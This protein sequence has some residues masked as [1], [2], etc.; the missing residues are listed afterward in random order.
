MFW[1]FLF[2]I[3]FSHPTTTEPLLPLNP[4]FPPLSCLLYPCDHLNF[5]SVF[6]FVFNFLLLLCGSHSMHPIPTH[7]SILSALC[8]SKL[9]LQ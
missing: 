7:L 8:P 5:L 1:S 4:T 9:P 2:S 6:V 3:A